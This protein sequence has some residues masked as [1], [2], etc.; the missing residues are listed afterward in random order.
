MFACDFTE[1]KEM[2]SSSNRL[3]TMI[4]ELKAAGLDNDTI[5]ARAHVAR[6]AVYP[7]PPTVFRLC[8]Y[9]DALFLASA[10]VEAAQGPRQTAARAVMSS[11]PNRQVPHCDRMAA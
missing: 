11:R 3:R 8:R 5:A 6:G 2:P 1:G 10:S 7:A 4:N 9:D